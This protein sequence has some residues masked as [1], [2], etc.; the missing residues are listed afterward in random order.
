MNTKLKRDVIP[1]LRQQG[2]K[3]SMPHFR[4]ARPEQ[5]DLLTF[6]F[7]RH[8]GGFVVEVARCAPTGVTTYWGKVIAPGQVTA[9][10]VHPEARTRIKPSTGSAPDFWFKYEDGNFDA[11]VAQV[12]DALTSARDYWGECE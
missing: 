4:R 2:F 8:D 5:I 9:H 6:Q 3:G 11:C 10:D 1:T 12:I 7:D